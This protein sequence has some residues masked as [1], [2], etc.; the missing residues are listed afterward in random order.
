M[1]SWRRRRAYDRGEDGVE[2]IR[3]VV[4]AGIN[5]NRR[6]EGFDVERLLDSPTSPVLLGAKNGDIFFPEMVAI[7]T[8]VLKHS[9]F[10]FPERV[11]LSGGVVLETSLGGALGFS[12]I[13]AWAWC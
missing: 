1:G 13:P 5:V 8:S 7:F 9:R 6:G 12:N 10:V 2:V 11:R 3:E 4:A